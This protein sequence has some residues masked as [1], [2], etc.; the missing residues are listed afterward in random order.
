MS[1]KVIAIKKNT[2]SPMPTSLKI[3]GLN[4]VAEPLEGRPP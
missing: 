3:R 1:L 4:V 2:I